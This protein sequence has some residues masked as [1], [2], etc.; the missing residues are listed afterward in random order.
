M[1][2]NI[3]NALI[4]KIFTIIP[5]SVLSKHAGK[6]QGF[7]GKY[8]MSRFFEKGNA[9]LINYMFSVSDI[10]NGD[11]ILDI[12]FGPGQ[13]FKHILKDYDNCFMAG[14]DISEDMIKRAKKHF[15]KYIKQEKL[16]LKLASVEKIPYNNNFFDTVF[17]AN[18]IYFW[19]NTDKCM[20]E[21]LRTLKPGGKVIIGY[22]T[23]E[24][25]EKL[26]LDKNIFT[27]YDINEIEIMMKKAGFR[28]IETQTRTEIE[29]DSYCTIGTK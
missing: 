25:L 27:F 5:S 29:F 21:I 16:E 28:K 17:T 4:Q 13:F 26:T 1:K 23:R 12:G 6:P 7:F 19:Q 2:T 24:Q 18:T 22:R 9:K 20:K 15:S 3:L 10:K 8:I 11:S 14:I